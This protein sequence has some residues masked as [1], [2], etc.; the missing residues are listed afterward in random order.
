MNCDRLMQKILRELSCDAVVVNL[1]E[2]PF[3]KGVDIDQLKGKDK[4]AP[5][6]DLLNRMYRLLKQM[7]KGN[8]NNSRRILIHLQVFRYDRNERIAFAR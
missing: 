6:V 3:R 7:A 2:L 5:L 8:L 1:L 4:F